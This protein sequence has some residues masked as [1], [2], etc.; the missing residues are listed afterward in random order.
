MKQTKKAIYAKHGIEYN[1]GKVLYNGRWIAELLKAGNSKTGKRVYTWSMPAGTAGTCICDCVGCYAKTGFYQM[2]SVKKALEL[3]Q[4]IVEN[5]ITFFYNAVSAQLEI[6]GS[7]ELRIHAAGDFN[8]RNSREYAETW[9]RIARENKNILMWTY[10][11]IHEYE[12]LFD[13]I[14]NAHIVKSVIDGIG[15][16]F[17]H[18][19]YILATYHKLQAMGANVYICRCGIDKNQHCENCGHC[20]K[21]DFVLFI[22]HSTDYKAE[23]DPI[24]NELKTVIDAQKD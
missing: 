24:F 9:Q 19:D 13:G 16:N 15:Y 1:C 12:S 18:C 5:D 6:I 11:K 22:E 23:S 17:G 7:G 14:A 10:T 20:G 8:T 21:A 3:N 4:S 2:A